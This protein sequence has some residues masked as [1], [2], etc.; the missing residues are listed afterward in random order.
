ML[1]VRRAELG[2][3]VADELRS[4]GTDARFVQA[5]VSRP[6]DVERLMSETVDAYGRLDGAFNNAAT[7]DGAFALTA[8]AGRSTTSSF[9]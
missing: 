4:A 3:Q 2:G 7:T 8:D 5:D 1:A 6:E 9:G